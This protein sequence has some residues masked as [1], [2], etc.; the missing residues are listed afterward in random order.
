MQRRFIVEQVFDKLCRNIRIDHRAGRHNAV[1]LFLAFKDFTG[2]RISVIAEVECNDIRALVARFTGFKFKDGA[3]DNAGA[4]L[5]R[6][7]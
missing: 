3:P 2:E 1:K 5:G 6:D 7:F 4:V